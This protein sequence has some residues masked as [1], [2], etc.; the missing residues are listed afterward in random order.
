MT[1]FVS[2]WNSDNSTSNDLWDNWNST[3]NYSKPKAV[4]D[5]EFD[6]A[7]EQVDKK[8][9]KWKY[10]AK[11]KNIPKGEEINQSNETEI[12]EA[13]YGEKK[14]DP[15]ILIPIELIVDGNIIAPD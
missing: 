13:G 9:N 14:T 1:W 7:L 2:F 11:K 3:D 15:T 5:D 10:R 4:S 12:I 6:K 8:V